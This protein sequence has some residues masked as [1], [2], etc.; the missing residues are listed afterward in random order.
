MKAWV[1]YIYKEGMDYLEEGY[2]TGSNFKVTP[3]LS[4]AKIYSIFTHAYN[5]DPMRRKRKQ[6]DV[7]RNMHVEVRTVNIEELPTQ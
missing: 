4:A 5:S 3:N 7:Y 6:P 2:Y 1:V